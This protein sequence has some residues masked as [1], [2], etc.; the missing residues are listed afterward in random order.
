MSP[1]GGLGATAALSF[2]LLMS[3]GKAIIEDFKRHTED[4]KTNTSQTTIVNPSNG[5]KG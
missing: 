4:E 5:R 2:V 3:G 1:F